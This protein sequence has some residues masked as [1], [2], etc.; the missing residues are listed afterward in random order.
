MKLLGANWKTTVSMIGATL[1]SALTF[2]ATVSYDQGP[3]ALVIPPKYKPTVTLIA[4]TAAMVL[5]FWNGIQQKSKDVTGGMVQ[6]TASGAVADAGTQT[7]V[8]ATVKATIAS[9]E[10]V[11]PEQKSKA[12]S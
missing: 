12:L 9:G 11:T 10:T 7:L 4:G 8:D 1:M 5:F 3:I 2:L 6:Q